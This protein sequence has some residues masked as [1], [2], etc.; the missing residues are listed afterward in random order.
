MK[1]YLSLGDL[2]E[3]KEKKTQKKREE[4]KSFVFDY[5]EFTDR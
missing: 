4:I 3:A 2:R 5:I 1:V